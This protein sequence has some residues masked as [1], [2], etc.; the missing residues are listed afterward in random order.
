MLLKRILT[1][2]LFLVISPVLLSAQ[3]NP[4]GGFLVES[5]PAGAEIILR[6]EVVVTGVTPTIFSQPLF[7]E[8]QVE[9]N[10]FGYENYS[11]RV[12]LD[13]TKPLTLTVKLTPK[14]RYKAAVRSM[15]IP[16]WGQIYGEQKTKGFLLNVLAIGSVAAYLISDH[17]YNN[18][19]D[20]YQAS[21]RTY[22]STVANGGSYAD[23]RSRYLKLTEN[24]EDAYDAETRRRIS[25][26]AVIGV[27]GI[28]L[29]DALFFFPQEKGTFSVKGLTVKPSTDFST[30]GIQ[31]SMSF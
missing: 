23:I 4:Q 25:I 24:R 16:G 22:D 14:T 10:K 9:I 28:N 21:L 2:F 27:W 29:L 5:T 8:Y 3:T 6:G 31:L 15:L 26:G 18:A 20:D 30:V 1:A 13:P 17:N 12:V 7:G 11:S 19:Y